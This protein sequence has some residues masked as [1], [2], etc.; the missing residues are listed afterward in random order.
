M[1][2]KVYPKIASYKKRSRIFIPKAMFV[3]Q[4][5]ILVKMRLQG[6]GFGIK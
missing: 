6:F 1:V 2:Q 5:L 3:I 4:N